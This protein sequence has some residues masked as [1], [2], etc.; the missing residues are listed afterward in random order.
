MKHSLVLKVTMILMEILIQLH[1]SFILKM[2]MIKFLLMWIDLKGVLHLRKV[3]Y[4]SILID[5]L[6]MMENGSIKIHIDHNIKNIPMWS[7][8]KIK[9]IMSERFNVYMISL[10]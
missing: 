6:M 9:I 3:Q 10:C 5:F 8:S 4:G 7:L 2:K 1:L